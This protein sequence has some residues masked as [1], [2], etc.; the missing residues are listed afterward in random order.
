MVVGAL[1]LFALAYATEIATRKPLAEANQAS[2]AAGAFANNN[3]RNAEVIEAMG[4]LPAI[5]E[6]GLRSTC[7]FWKTKR[8]L[9]TALQKSVPS[10]S[11][12]GFLCNRWH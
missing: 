4:M 11:L 6:N 1:I 10:P 3:L 2:I 5:R 9:P 7:E 12:Y 8:W